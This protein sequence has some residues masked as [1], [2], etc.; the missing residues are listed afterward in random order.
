MY[1]VNLASCKHSRTPVFR[2]IQ[3]SWPKGSCRRSR[4]WRESR[5]V[6][7]WRPW[8]LDTVGETGCLE[9]LS[10]LSA[11]TL[12]SPPLLSFGVPL[13]SWADLPHL[14]SPAW[15]DRLL[16]LHHGWWV[17]SL[18]SCLPLLD[19]FPSPSHTAQGCIS[20]TTLLYYNSLLSL[21][22]SDDFTPSD[23][24]AQ[25]FTVWPPSLPFSYLGADIFIQ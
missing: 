9:I 4:G 21:L 24:A 13:S 12:R 25:A 20:V 15:A 23:W 8:W 19:F 16:H 18:V 10:S 2:W 14:P 7:F 5:V 3:V 1:W 22:R 6:A 11:S 17:G